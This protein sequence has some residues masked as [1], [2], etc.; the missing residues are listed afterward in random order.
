MDRGGGEQAR[1]RYRKQPQQDNPDLKVV[2]PRFQGIR[3]VILKGQMP[4]EDT[5]KV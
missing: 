3:Q 2:R 1:K 5:C 4:V